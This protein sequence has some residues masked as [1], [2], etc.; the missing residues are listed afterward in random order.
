MVGKRE[1]IC[2]QGAQP[3]ISGGLLSAGAS[4]GA[5]PGSDS[6]LIIISSDFFLWRY[7]L[8]LS[9]RDMLLLMFVWPLVEGGFL[10]SLPWLQGPKG[11]PKVSQ[12]VN[13]WEVPKSHYAGIPCVLLSATSLCYICIIPVVRYTVFQ[14]IHTCWHPWRPLV[15]SLPYIR[16]STY[17]LTVVTSEVPHCL[18]RGKPRHFL[19]THSHPFFQDKGCKTSYPT[20]QRHIDGY[21]FWMGVAMRYLRRFIGWVQR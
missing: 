3:A 1:S 20:V 7:P 12:R 19:C 6:S 17:M 9:C 15:A 2:A 14:V 16:I 10:L 8:I 4:S 5:I 18:S 11:S 21:T 13:Y